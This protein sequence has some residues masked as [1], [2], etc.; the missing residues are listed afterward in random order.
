MELI[1]I[2]NAYLSFFEARAGGGGAE[3]P[4]VRKFSTSSI[5]ACLWMH[6]AAYKFFS[7]STP[8]IGSNPVLYAHH[9]SFARLEDEKEIIKDKKIRVCELKNKRVPYMQKYKFSHARST[10]RVK[11][12]NFN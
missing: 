11:Y 8:G 7:Y 3:I 6:G 4:F 10:G 1:C 5:S 12:F 2:K 9:P